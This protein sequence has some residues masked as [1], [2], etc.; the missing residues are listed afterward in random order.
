MPSEKFKVCW[1]HHPTGKCGISE[2]Q[3]ENEMQL[4]RL[5]NGWNGSNPTEWH[6]WYS[7]YPEE[8]IN[9]IKESER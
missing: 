4:L 8:A 7:H 3:C 1:Y 2:H 6:Y 9:A 5:I